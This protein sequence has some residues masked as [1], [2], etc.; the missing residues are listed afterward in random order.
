MEVTLRATRFTP[1]LNVFAY[2]ILY[3][4]G[5]IKKMRIITNIV[6]IFILFIVFLTSC[7]DNDY[8]NEEYGLTTNFESKFEYSYSGGY[9]V[10]VDG[11]ITGYFSRISFDNYLER[12]QYIFLDDSIEYKLFNT[13]EIADSLMDTLEYIFEQLGY[14]SF[15]QILPIF[16]ESPKMYE[17]SS[18]IFYA[19]RKSINDTLKTL[20]VLGGAIN[21]YFPDE[22]YVF[23]T[24]FNNVWTKIKVRNP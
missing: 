6:I 16:T 24:L 11:M 23:S 5:I 7:T 22:Y 12:Y 3:P 17:P 2:F 20:T 13:K 8:K 15:P 9:D 1:F 4:L 14:L 10:L 21:G 19:Y 18:N